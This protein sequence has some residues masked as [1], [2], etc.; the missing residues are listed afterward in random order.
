MCDIGESCPFWDKVDIDR[1]MITIYNVGLDAVAGRDG[2]NNGI[3]V[4]IY[5]GKNITVEDNYY[6]LLICNSVFE[7]VPVEQRSL[8]LAEMR[9]VPKKIF[10]Q[11]PSVSI[12]L[13]MCIFC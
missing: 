1:K 7:H 8:L 3:T 5:D 4:R 9:R 12:I 13:L 11:T 10:C 2:D 6:D